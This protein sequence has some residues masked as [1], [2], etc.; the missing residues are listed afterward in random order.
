MEIISVD[1]VK[2]TFKVKIHGG[3]LHLGKSEGSIKEL[4]LHTHT[5]DGIKKAFGADIYKVPPLT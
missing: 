3:E 4:P 5:F 1:T 2:G